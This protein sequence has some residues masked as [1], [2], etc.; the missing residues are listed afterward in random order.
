MSDHDLLNALPL[1]LQLYIVEAVPVGERCDRAA[2]ALASPHL[3]A[4]CREQLPSYQGLEIAIAFHLV[5]GGTIDEQL[6]RRY[7]RRSEATPEGCDWL[8]GAAAEGV[9]VATGLQILVTVSSDAEPGECW[10]LTQTDSTAGTLLRRG[11]GGDTGHYEG[12]AG[13]EHLVCFE[14]SGRAVAHFEGEK[15]AERTVRLHHPGSGDVVPHPGS[16]QSGP[17]LQA[18][19][20]PADAAGWHRS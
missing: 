17:R 13:S 10:H 2:L 19:L 14:T 15:G 7:A 1:E 3:L 20:G 16:K 11:K 6:L 9:A 5:L 8:A 18:P 12:E 4:A